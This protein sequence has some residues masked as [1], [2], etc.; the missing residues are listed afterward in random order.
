MEDRQ[1]KK[2]EQR[3]RNLRKEDGDV[4]IKYILWSKI[5]KYIWKESIKMKFGWKKKGKD[6]FKKQKYNCR[7][8][9]RLR[10]RFPEK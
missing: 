6:R 7:D 10:E 1:K 5:D 9:E 4:M 8:T 3:K 2:K